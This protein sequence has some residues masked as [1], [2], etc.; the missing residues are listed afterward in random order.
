MVAYLYPVDRMDILHAIEYNLPYFLQWL[1]RP[2]RTD[3]IPLHQ[4]IA[5]RQQLDG[6]NEQSFS[7]PLVGQQRSKRWR[8]TFSVLPSGPI[9]L[10]LLFANLSLFRTTFP[11]LIISHVTPSSSTFTACET[12]TPRARSLM[13]SRDLIIR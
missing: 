6:L 10:C 8:L 4:Y 2:H 3:G 1:V 7:A 11:I 13:R 9:I 5:P 12:A